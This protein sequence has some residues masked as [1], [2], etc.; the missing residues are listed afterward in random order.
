MSIIFELALPD[1]QVRLHGG[2]GMVVEQDECWNVNPSGSKWVAGS[3]I[4][5]HVIASMIAT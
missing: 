1:L 4:D 5:L 3:E 2:G